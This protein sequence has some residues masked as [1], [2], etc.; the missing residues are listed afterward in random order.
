[1]VLIGRLLALGWLDTLEGSN[2][3]AVGA[4]AL[5]VLMIAYLPA[6]DQLLSSGESTVGFIGLL[7]LWM[8]TRRTTAPSPA[9]E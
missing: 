1:M 8:W 3:F 6:N 5:L 7:A 4:F 9:S 2:P